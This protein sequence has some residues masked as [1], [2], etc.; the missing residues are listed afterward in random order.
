MH[1]TYRHGK[2][3]KAKD[4]PTVP[5]IEVTPEMLSAASSVFEKY[6][7]GELGYDLRAPCVTEVYRAMYAAR[8]K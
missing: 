4:R 1:L 6:Y 3:D 7:M 8:R 2:P 5:E